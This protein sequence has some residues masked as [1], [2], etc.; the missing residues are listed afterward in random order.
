MIHAVAAYA[1]RRAKSC[2]DYAPYATLLPIA[3]LRQLTL[4]F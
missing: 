1:A 3:M 4:I 2:R